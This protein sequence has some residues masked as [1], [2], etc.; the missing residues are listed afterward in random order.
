MNYEVRVIYFVGDRQEY[1]I[2]TWVLVAPDKRTAEEYAV[3]KSVLNY[4]APVFID[5]VYV[6]EV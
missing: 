5:N 1:H 4:D 2:D 6:E 3:G